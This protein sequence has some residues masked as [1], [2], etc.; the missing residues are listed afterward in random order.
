V[1]SEFLD[2]RLTLPKEQFRDALMTAVFTYFYH[3][4]KT[5]IEHLI[6]SVKKGI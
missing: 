4:K 2:F 3:Q 1:K 6:S 5:Q